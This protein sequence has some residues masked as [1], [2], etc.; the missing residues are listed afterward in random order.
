MRA[1]VLTAYGQDWPRVAEQCP[2]RD[3]AG[4]LVAAQ[5]R[6]GRVR[7]AAGQQAVVAGGRAGARLGGVWAAWRRH[8]GRPAA[9]RG[10]EERKFFFFEF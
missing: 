5:G 2:G 9:A 6:A 4:R 7:M 3:G 1:R 10:A 8:V